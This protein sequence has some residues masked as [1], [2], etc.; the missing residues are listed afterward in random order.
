M[1]W[2]GLSI[3]ILNNCAINFNIYASVVRKFWRAV[4]GYENLMDPLKHT[5]LELG[6]TLEEWVLWIRNI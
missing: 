5:F 4:W 1:G 2:L 6:Y 3:F